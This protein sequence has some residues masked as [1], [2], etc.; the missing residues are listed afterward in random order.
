MG[1]LDKL[2]RTKAVDPGERRNRLLKQG[3]ITDGVVIDTHMD[4]TGNEVAHYLYTLNGV[5]FE[6]VDILTELQRKDRVRYAPGSRV[7]VRYDP[8]NQGNSVLE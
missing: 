4:D 8:K 2:K 1:L 3:R 5:D 6:S 7:G